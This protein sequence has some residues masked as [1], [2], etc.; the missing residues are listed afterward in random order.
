MNSILCT[1]PKHP[2]WP[3]LEKFANEWGFDLQSSIE[4]LQ[5]GEYLFLVSCT[6]FVEKSVR[7]RF[8]RVLVLHE[9]DLPKGRGWSPLAWQILEGKQEICISLIE[10]EDKIDSGRIW[11]QEIVHIPK[12]ELA[13]GISRIIWGAKQ[14][15]IKRCIGQPLIPREQVGEPTYYKRRTPEDSRLDPFRSIA[16]Q[17]ELLR[18][19]EPRFPAFFEY[20]GRRYEVTLR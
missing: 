10:A 6:Q 2:I 4:G 12:H 17:F 8:K 19:C 7:D 5:G 18:I 3:S 20:R 14:R 13:D 11:A 1:D 16:D 15:L 9:S